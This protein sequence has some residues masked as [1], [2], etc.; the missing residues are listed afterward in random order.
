MDWKGLVQ[1]ALMGNGAASSASLLRCTV[2]SLLCCIVV[3]LLCR[4][5]CGCNRLLP[6]EL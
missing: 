4:G 1:F 5:D 2:I 6:Q 3:S